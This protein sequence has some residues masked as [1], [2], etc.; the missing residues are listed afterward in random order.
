MPIRLYTIP[1]YSRFILC[2]FWSKS[3][4][5]PFIPFWQSPT[6]KICILYFSIKIRIFLWFAHKNCCTCQACSKTAIKMT[7]FNDCYVLNGHTFFSRTNYC[8][9]MAGTKTLPDRPSLETVRLYQSCVASRTWDSIN[10][11]WDWALLLVLVRWPKC[12]VQLTALGWLRKVR[13]DIS[14]WKIGTM[15][16]RK[17]QNW[18]VGCNLS[19]TATK[20]TIR[21]NSAVWEISNKYFDQPLRLFLD[22]VPDHSGC[23]IEWV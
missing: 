5:K 18:S 3:G 23:D 4:S 19:K 20:K 13:L 21:Q 17:Q 15:K 7:I 2:L 14:W 16:N 9:K 12:Q 11:L 8:W 1:T 6:I 10:Y 22:T